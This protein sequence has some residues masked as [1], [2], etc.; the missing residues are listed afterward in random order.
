MCVA[1]VPAATGVCC[2]WQDHPGLQR[3]ALQD[4]QAPHDPGR[5]QGPGHMPALPLAAAAAREG[6]RADAE[7]RR[8]GRGRGLRIWRWQGGIL[9]CWGIR[10][11]G[12]LTDI[13]G[14]IEH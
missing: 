5:D 9:L 7:L 2:Q 11:D 1:A 13:L 8:D 10:R 3:G 12:L 4:V 14:S 6:A